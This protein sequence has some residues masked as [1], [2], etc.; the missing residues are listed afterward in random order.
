MQNNGYFNDWNGYLNQL[1]DLILALA[2][3]LIG[4][5]VAK[6]IE[7]G[8]EKALRKSKINDK[9]HSTGE[10][11]KYPVEKV[12]SKV[13]YYIILAFVFIWFFN[14]LSL[15]FIAT[16]LIGMLSSI[17]AFVPN[18]LKAALILVL[19]YVIATLLKMFIQKVGKRGR[20]DSVLQKINAAETKEDADRLIDNAAKIV[21]YLVLLIFLP[22]VLSALQITGVSEP[23]SGMVDSFLSFIPRLLAAALIVVVGWFVAKLVRDILTN[24]LQ[25][26]GTERLAGR[27]GLTKLVQGITI[28]SFIG[29]IVYVLILIPVAISAL[30]QLNIDGISEPAIAMLND[31]LTMLPNIA[32]AIVLIMVGIWAGRFIGTMVSTLLGRMGIDAMM[33]KM[34]IGQWNPAQ[35]NTSLSKIIG[36][37]VQILIVLL[38]TVEALQLVNLDFMV[39]LATGVIAY[40]PS[41]IA[42][43]IILAVGLFLGNFVKQ[44][45]LN[46]VKGPEFKLISS[47]AKYTII[48]LAF[49]MALDQL[50]VADSIVNS[51]FILILGG[52]ALAFGLAFGLGGKD[53]AS[54]YLSKLDRTIEKT[55]ID[56]EAMKSNSP[57]NPGNPSINSKPNTNPVNRNPVSKPNTNPNSMNQGLNNFGAN[58]G[59]NNNDGPIIP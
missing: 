40:L 59:S 34:G 52:F 5:L 25:S 35:S 37:I 26:I 19:A 42:A 1:P 43:V 44:I 57:M 4:W 46:I 8:I 32:V 24:F 16:P 17:T 51:A 15:S 20:M 39:T 18:V 27:I 28:S 41:V 3:L 29:N 7:K 6:V 2:V 53:F 14:I 13:I 22:G 33:S 49:F 12:V 38:F 50:G 45:L 31:V 36:N 48:A 58:P 54:N 21:F 55:S 11:Q 47:I 30:E 56:K 9:L 23:F 10:P